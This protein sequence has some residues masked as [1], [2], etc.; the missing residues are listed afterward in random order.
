MMLPPV[1][2]SKEA[3]LSRT[4]QEIFES[5][6]NSGSVSRNADSLAASDGYCETRECARAAVA[7]S[8][9]RLPGGDTLI[10]PGAAAKMVISCSAGTRVGSASSDPHRLS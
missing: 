1:S 5:Y 4:P 2:E 3:P 10:A 6:V 8:S 9:G 7:H